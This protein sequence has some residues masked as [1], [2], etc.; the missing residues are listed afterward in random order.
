MPEALLIVMAY[1][2]GS[3]PWGLLIAGICCGV[4]LRRSGSGN[5]GATNVARLC[6]FGYGVATLLCDLLKGSL[7]VWLAPHINTSPVFVSAVGL[8]CVVGHVFSCFIKFRGGKAVATSIGVFLPLA[9]WQLL[10]AAVCCLLVIWRSGYVSLGS[11]TFVTAMPPL[12]AVC[13]LWQWLPL[14][15]CIFALVLCKH[16]ENIRRLRNGTEKSW[17]KSRQHA[18]KTHENS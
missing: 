7:P 5:T 18:D 15:L 14:S 10:T 12:L 13:G 3:A 2:L 4:D 17:Q 9:F 1:L 8:A 11:L 16:A 6:G